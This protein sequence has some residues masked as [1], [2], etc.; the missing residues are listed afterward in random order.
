MSGFKPLYLESYDDFVKEIALRISRETEGKV[1]IICPKT[2]EE[3][4]RDLSTYKCQFIVEYPFRKFILAELPIMVGSK[5]GELTD[6]LL[7]GYFVVE[8]R[9][10]ALVPQE[11]RDFL[12]IAVTLSKDTYICKLKWRELSGS[13]KDEKHVCILEIEAY[14]PWGHSSKSSKKEM[15]RIR[16]NFMVDG[17]NPVD[18]SESFSSDSENDED[19]EDAKKAKPRKSWMSIDDFLKTLLGKEWE[20]ILLS[21]TLY[22]QRIHAFLISV[23]VDK[24]RGSFYTDHVKRC[25]F[26][27]NL[28]ERDS[29]IC[30]AVCRTV[31]T[32][33]GLREKDDLDDPT[34]TRIETPVHLIRRVLWKNDFVKELGNRCEEVTKNIKTGNWVSLYNLKM[35][36]ISGPLSVKS[37]LDSLSHLRKIS[38]PVDPNTNNKIIRGLHNGSLGFTCVCE[39]PEG[40]DVG[41]T[42]HLAST[43]FV[44]SE[45]SSKN[46]EILERFL[47]RFGVDRKLNKDRGFVFVN[48]LPRFTTNT[49]SFVNEFFLFREKFPI[50]GIN[51]YVSSDGDIRISCDSG[52]FIR[53]IVMMSENKE[54][55]CHVDPAE[56]I[57]IPLFTDLTRKSM[58]QKGIKRALVEIHD[59]S[60]FGYI[61][62]TIPFS[63]HDQSPR[64]VFQCSMTKQAIPLNS[65]E[66]RDFPYDLKLLAYGQKPLCTTQISEDL[67]L[68]ENP[69]GINV[70][71]AILCY[72]GYN[73]EDAIIFSESA[74]K[75][76]L[77]ANK[78]YH[79]IEITTNFH[80]QEKF[81]RVSSDFE[82]FDE[83]GII[84]ERQ[85]IQ[86]N[87]VI[88]VRYRPQE[89]DKHFFEERCKIG[90]TSRV[91]K[92]EKNQKD[93]GSRIIRI[94]ILSIHMEVDIG[95]KFTSRHAQKGVASFMMKQSDLPFDKDGIS[96]DIIINPH[97]IPSRMTIGQILEI[98]LSTLAALNGEIIDGTPFLSYPPADWD[99]SILYCGMTGEIMGEALM[100][101]CYYQALRHQS[102]EKAFSR[103]GGPVQI[104][105]RQPVEGRSKGGGLRFGEMEKDCMIAHNASFTLQDKLMNDSDPIDVSVCKNCG[106]TEFQE[107]TCVNCNNEESAIVR[108]PYSFRLLCQE[109]TAANLRLRGFPE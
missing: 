68:D 32:L 5:F 107:H 63:N 31:E 85:I 29:L 8:G 30:L 92:V 22:P 82:R 12:R 25:F 80:I 94:C 100:G 28:N 39:T 86:D 87:D 40:K 74:I 55:I 47:S 89:K 48:G 69:N 38:A 57:Y 37:D 102:R 101:L 1:K 35:K 15:I 67:N 109:M 97:C 96:P 81:V 50:I 17:K 59:S 54:Y 98:S 45:L 73:Q 27:M 51:I 56:Q 11:R 9:K 84:R 104:F 13:E 18:P 33:L 95:D 106:E 99:K 14:S 108:M 36:G 93:N 19:Y 78:K 16:T 60:M 62:S 52:R 71:V 3:C 6:R 61:A 76:D 66:M 58:T 103:S 53:P 64:I 44:S 105:S 90:S 91:I 46:M 65:E 24:K 49:L 70:V 23:G 88:A 21:H 34:Y 4:L 77:F 10:R 83:E 79:T 26:S 20:K 43:C 42:K 7:L 72:T 75:R 2:S 41:I